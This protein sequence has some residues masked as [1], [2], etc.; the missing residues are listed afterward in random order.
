MRRDFYIGGIVSLGVHFGL[1]GFNPTAAVAVTTAKPPEPPPFIEVRKV[2]EV[3]EE[4]PPGDAR[5]KSSV[6]DVVRPPSLPD[7][8]QVPRP[9]SF[10]TPVQPVL[11]GKINPKMV[12][13]PEF[14]PRGPGEGGSAIFEISALD[15]QPSPKFQAKPVYPFEMRRG[16]FTGE[17]VVDFIVD[18]KGDVQSAYAARSTRREFEESAVQAVSKWK[19]RPGKKAGGAVSVHMQV[20]IVFSLNGE[21]D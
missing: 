18:A 21:R 12:A 8:P 5:E 9:D 4:R 19:F 20:P 16:G 11:D 2:E 15:Q 1:A 10:V 3:F 6:T 14:S 7:A 17:V 13:A